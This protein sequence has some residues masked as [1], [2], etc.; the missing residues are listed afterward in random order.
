[1]SRVPSFFRQRSY[2]VGG[3]L[4][5]R[6]LGVEAGAPLLPALDLLRISDLFARESLASHLHDRTSPELFD[7]SIT[8]CSP[9]MRA[10]S[11][12]PTSAGAR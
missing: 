3:E 2:L 11:P 5:P 8:L 1:M 12:D 7:I 6:V 9:L 4:P 10:L